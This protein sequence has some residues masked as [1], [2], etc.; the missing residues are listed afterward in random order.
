MGKA[1]G[2]RVPPRREIHRGLVGEREG[3]SL[4][5]QIMLN[6]IV[7][8]Q[9]GRAWIGFFSYDRRTWWQAANVCFTKRG[10]CAALLGT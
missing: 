3:R 6:L 2:L 7:K 9:D 10:K 4:T 5:A 8:E 1:C